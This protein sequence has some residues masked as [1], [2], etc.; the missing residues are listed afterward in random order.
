MDERVAAIT[1]QLQGS[2][3]TAEEPNLK[4]QAPAAPTAHTCAARLS[5]ALPTYDTKQCATAKA[6]I[7]GSNELIQ[8]VA[9]DF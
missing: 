4:S 2:A 8:T 3:F 9:A 6:L 5:Q 7:Y 1:L